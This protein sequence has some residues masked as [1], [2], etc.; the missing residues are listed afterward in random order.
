MVKLV[1]LDAR[2]A[3]NLTTFVGDGAHLPWTTPTRR[4]PLQNV[5]AFVV[6]AQRL[7]A[8]GV[9]ETFAV[10]DTE[11]LLGIAVLAR[12][13]A[14]PDRA[15]MGYWIGPPDRG[16]G[17]AT[18]AARQLVTRGFGRMK[19][20][21]VF[22]RCASANRASTRVVEK[23]GFRFVGLEPALEHP[24]SVGEPIRRYE[25]TRGEWLER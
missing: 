13:P 24:E 10:C 3:P 1:P 9:R 17:Y 4:S 2:H 23:L 22:A 8:R 7:R 19:L 14:A 20:A 12:D 15:E 11:R 18:A 16:H 6:H 25:M 5:L 21:L